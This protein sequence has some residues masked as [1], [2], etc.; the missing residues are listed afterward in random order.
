M[1]HKHEMSANV[2]LDGVDCRNSF[3]AC[4]A[5]SATHRRPIKSDNAVEDDEVP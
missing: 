3:P 4:K 2:F 5:N 1:V